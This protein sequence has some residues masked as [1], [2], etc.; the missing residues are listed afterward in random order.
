MDGVGRCNW[1]SSPSCTRS[2]KTMSSYVRDRCPFQ[3]GQQVAAQSVIKMS[4]KAKFIFV[5]DD[6][7]KEHP[8]RFK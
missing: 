6:D 1:V 7:Q 2:A 4:P 8:C 3:S 5:I